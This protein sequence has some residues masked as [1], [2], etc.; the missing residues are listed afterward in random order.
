MASPQ[1]CIIL[2]VHESCNGQRNWTR[3]TAQMS[4][5]IMPFYIQAMSTTHGLDFLLVPIVHLCP[6]PNVPPLPTQL[7]WDL[8]H[9][10]NGYIESKR[11]NPFQAKERLETINQCLC[12]YLDH[13]SW[14]GLQQTKRSNVSTCVGCLKLQNDRCGNKAKA[15]GCC[16]TN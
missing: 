7:Q 9:D 15:L 11:K 8:D 14:E 16:K 10:L 5:E 6:F 2:S 3:M 4:M 12:K 13:F 1:P